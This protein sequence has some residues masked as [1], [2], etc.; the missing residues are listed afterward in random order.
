MDVNSGDLTEVAR[1]KTGKEPVAIAQDPQNRFVYVANAGSNNVSAFAIN[2]STGALTEV[3]GSPYATGE[4]PASISVDANGWYVY[5]LNHGSQDMSVFLIHVKK[6]QLA[7]VQGS[8]VPIKKQ[9]QKLTT[10]PTSR[11]VYVNARDDK[12]INVYRF[13]QA[14]T[15]SI[16]EISDY[17]SPFIFNTDPSDVAIDPTGRFALILQSEAK[18]ISMFFVHVAT[19]ALIPIQDNLQP[20]PFQGE[21]AV[22]ALFHP[23]GK[24]AYV[25][26][27]DS[28]NIIQLQVERLNGILSESAQPVATNGKPLSFTIDPSGRYLYV[29]N[30]NEKGLIKFG[31]DKSSGKLTNLG[32]IKL[33]YSPAAM[34]ISREFK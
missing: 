33:P 32:I 30:E 34:A 18:Q 24:F 11:F 16:F 10:D 1:A 29:V 20:Y 9:P 7:E 2:N 3:E 26:N 27:R 23:N 8:P 14:I 21:G 13:R 25:L 6:G 5:T 28:K 22:K 12:S 19:G 31:I 17:G 15:P 4:N